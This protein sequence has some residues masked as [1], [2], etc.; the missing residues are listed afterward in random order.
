MP[1]IRNHGVRMAIWKQ[2]TLFAF[3]KNGAIVS[4]VSVVSVVA[5]AAA[6]YL[7]LHYYFIAFRFVVVAAL[8][9]TAFYMGVATLSASLK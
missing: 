8:I 2:T 5:A 6:T 3:I 9:F 4:V 1:W 7:L